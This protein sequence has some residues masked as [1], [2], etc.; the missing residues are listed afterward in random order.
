MVGTGVDPVTS[1]VSEGIGR[2]SGGRRRRSERVRPVQWAVRGL[3]PYPSVTPGS[4]CPPADLVTDDST[5]P[6]STP[7][8]RRSGQWRERHPQ[9]GQ[10]EG[11]SAHRAQ[12]QKGVVERARPGP[13]DSS[14]PI[15]PSPTDRGFPARSNSHRG[16]SRLDPVSRTARLP[17]GRLPHQ[18]RPFPPVSSYGRG[19][20]GSGT[21]YRAPDCGESVAHFS[22]TWQ[23]PPKPFV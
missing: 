23:R 3:R 5:G 10:Y 2:N 21:P 7:Q 4:P 13:A 9:T 15:G 11:Q 17:K 8:P 6:W 20:A 14:L 22:S 19:W 18:S 1:R 16:R 12:S